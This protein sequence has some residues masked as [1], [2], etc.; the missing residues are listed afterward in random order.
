MKKAIATLL[1]SLF[2]V[3]AQ[4]GTTN[5]TTPEFPERVTVINDKLLVDGNQCNSL[6]VMYREYFTPTLEEIIQYKYGITS[7]Y[8]IESDGRAFTVETIAPGVFGFDAQGQAGIAK[9]ALKDGA[10]LHYTLKSASCNLTI[11]TFRGN[12]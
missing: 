12:K 1:V 9:T 3:T 5:T 11:T 7:G 4:A 6:V 8:A 2:A 10:V